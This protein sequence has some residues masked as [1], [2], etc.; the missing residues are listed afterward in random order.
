MATCFL[1]FFLST[2]LIF[3]S[4]LPLVLAVSFLLRFSIMFFTSPFLL[5]Y[6]FISSFLSVSVFEIGS[7]TPCLEFAPEAKKDKED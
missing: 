6:P 3:L 2:V 4:L 1:S 7:L 5:L